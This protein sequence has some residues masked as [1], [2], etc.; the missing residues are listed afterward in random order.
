MPTETH[1]VCYAPKTD[2]LCRRARKR[3]KQDSL[4]TTDN[5]KTVLQVGTRAARL[6]ARFSRQ[7]TRCLFPAEDDAVL[8]LEPRKIEG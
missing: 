2:E 8:E 1:L 4:Q 7:V 3:E 6:S 5:F